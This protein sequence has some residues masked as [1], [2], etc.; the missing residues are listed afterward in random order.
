MIHPYISNIHNVKFLQLSTSCAVF[1]RKGRTFSINMDVHLVF[2]THI[3]SLTL[4]Q[5]A[6][7]EVFFFFDKYRTKKSTR[8]CEN[9]N[10][11]TSV[12]SKSQN[13]KQKWTWTVK[14]EDCTG[15]GT[16]N[17]PKTKNLLIKWQIRVRFLSNLMISCNK[18]R[19][20]NTIQNEQQMAEHIA[21]AIIKSDIC[22]IHMISLLGLEGGNSII[23]VKGVFPPKQPLFG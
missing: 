5:I 6:V 16:R 3:R 13:V 21:K 15:T 12:G 23:S 10:N 2:I 20:K 18:F 1:L 7:A 11:E 22:Y 17:E 4:V 14:T 9:L 19:K 8:T